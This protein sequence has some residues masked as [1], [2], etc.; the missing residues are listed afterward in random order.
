MAFYADFKYVSFI[1]LNVPIKSYKPEKICVIFEKGEKTPQKTQEILMQRAPSDSACYGTLLWRFQPP[2][3]KTWKLVF[4]KICVFCYC[5]F[6]LFFFSPRWSCQTNGPRILGEGLFERKLKL[7]KP[8]HSDQKYC[9]ANNP[10]P[11]PFSPEVIQ[12]KFW[13]LYFVHHVWKI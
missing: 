3:W 12:S 4:V 8:L 13:D 5:C 1:K 6:C 11:T 9:M 2:I 10:P 7:L